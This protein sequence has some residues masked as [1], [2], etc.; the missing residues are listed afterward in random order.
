MAKKP[1]GKRMRIYKEQSGICH[2]C[3]GKI[4][5]KL[6]DPHPKSFSLDHV[7]PRKYGGT[8]I[9]ENLAIAHK[10]CNRRRDFKL[11][12]GVRLWKAFKAHPMKS[13][14]RI[15]KSMLNRLNPFCSKSFLMEKVR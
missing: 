14:I 12:F 9:K 3:G 4:S 13:R 7:I 6:K 5:L 8:D 2:I 10:R 11:I 1:N 15:I